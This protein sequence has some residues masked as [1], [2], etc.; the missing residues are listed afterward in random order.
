MLG[1]HD[2]LA[3]A[4]RHRRVV[5]CRH[6]RF[7]SRRSRWLGRRGRSQVLSQ[8]GRGLCVHLPSVPLDRTSSAS[9]T[10]PVQCPALR[11]RVRR[12]WRPPLRRRRSDVLQFLGKLNLVEVIG[13]RSPPRSAMPDALEEGSGTGIGCPGGSETVASS[14]GLVASSRSRRR[15]QRVVDG[16]RRGRE[17]ALQACE[18]KADDHHPPA[19]PSPS[20]S[21]MSRG[22][23]SCS[24]TDVVEVTASYSS[25]S[26]PDNSNFA[27]S[28]RI[29]SERDGLPSKVR[30]FSFTSRR[31]TSLT[32]G[33][34][35]GPPLQFV[36]RR[37]PSN[38]SRDAIERS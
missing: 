14:A 34:S 18:R 13:S 33:T 31:I 1:E 26:G 25:F 12:Q 10:N 24:V 19:E 38:R 22:L 8:A 2:Q 36:A 32:S 29:A 15:Q 3:M 7:G 11:L 21:V 6:G 17:P 16:C 30:R 9:S 28:G 37:R 27:G 4:P 23:G 20:A 35:L 5:G